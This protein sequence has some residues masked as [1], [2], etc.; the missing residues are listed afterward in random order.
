MTRSTLESRSSIRTRKREQVRA[1]V[2][3][4]ALDL[5]RR[6]GFEQVTVERIAVEAGI[7]AA[8]FYRYF[9]TKDGVLFDYQSRWLQDVR[10]AADGLDV[11]RPRGEQVRYLLAVLMKIFDAELDSMQV[12]DEIVARNPVLLPRTLAVQR[13][14][15][16]ELA[17]S[18]ARRRDLEAGD[19]TAQADAAVVQVV[20]R[21]AFRRLRAGACASM[22]DSVTAAMRD[23]ATLATTCSPDEGDARAPGTRAHG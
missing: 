7:G 13:R 10:R 20:V 2:E 18:L 8:T 14:W 15:E 3:H 16:Q 11:T 17:E 23:L 9:G 21:L 19:L 6:H 22:A 4:V 1:R 5:F 12:R